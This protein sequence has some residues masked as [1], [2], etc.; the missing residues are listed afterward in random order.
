[1]VRKSC[2]TIECNIK[3][4]WL[5]V[6][7][8]ARTTVEKIGG[9]GASAPW[10]TLRFRNDSAN[11][12]QRPLPVILGRRRC[13]LARDCL[14]RRLRRFGRRFLRGNREDQLGIVIGCSVDPGGNLVPA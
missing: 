12:E 7:A 1:M 8:F 2:S 14:P 6:L 3:S 4:R 5:W 13:G 10:P 9:H 11:S